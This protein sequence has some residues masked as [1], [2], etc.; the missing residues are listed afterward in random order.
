[1][2]DPDV[3]TPMTEVEAMGGL[4]NRLRS[5]LDTD[6]RPLV[7]GFHA[8]GDAHTTTNPLYGRGCALAMVQAVLLADAFV[9]HRSDAI[10][11]SVA[12]EQ[13]SAREI[14]PWYH[15]AVDGDALRSTEPIDPQDPRFTL[16]D[17]MRVGAAAPSLLPITLRTLTLLDTPDVLADDPL[18]VETLMQLREQHVAK[19]AA[20]E[21]DGYQPP[22]QRADLL[23]AGSD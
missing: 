23:L 3:A 5:F 2:T 9:E 1:V 14:E 4:I 19:L 10:S 13:A 18:F 6:G 8:L 16:Y 20:R 21:A 7:T 17:L 11:R 22:I 15:F 12:Y